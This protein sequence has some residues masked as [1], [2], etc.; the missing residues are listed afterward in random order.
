MNTP[1]HLKYT[2]S[3]EWVE[4]HEDGT[5]T[6]GITDHA[7]AL[8]GDMVFVQLPKVGQSYSAGADCAVV[9]SV[10]SAA[11]VYAP[12]AGTVTHINE[13]LATAP[14]AINQ[15]AYN[16][17]IWKMKPDNSADVAMLL[18]ATDYLKIAAEGH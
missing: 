9:E 11:D 15:D 8:L 5:L 10:K 6:I 7:Q 3:H 2:A 13:A 14:E 4:T 1:T 18:S 17:W 12:I 16:A